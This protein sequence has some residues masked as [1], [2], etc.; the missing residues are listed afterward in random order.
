MKTNNVT[1]TRMFCVTLAFLLF[2]S[3]GVSHAKSGGKLNGQPFQEVQSQID[4]LNNKVDTIE[5]TVEG[6]KQQI[7]ALLAVDATLEERISLNEQFISDLR[8]ENLEIKLEMEEL[9]AEAEVLGEELDTNAINIQELALQHQANYAAI[10]ELQGE[11]ETLQADLDGKQDILD[12]SCPQGWVLYDISPNGAVTCEEMATPQ[13]DDVISQ[14]TQYVVRGEREELSPSEYHCYEWFLGVCISGSWWNSKATSY[15]QCPEGSIL[16]GGGAETNGATSDVQN[17]T[18]AP[19]YIS[20]CVR[21]SE[22]SFI[23][24]DYTD[25]DQVDHINVSVGGWSYLRTHVNGWAGS[26]FRVDGSTGYYSVQS[27]ALCSKYE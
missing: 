14:V 9:A 1:I 20:Y 21:T 18:S 8:A 26:A 25:S 23:C 6:I 10:V 17:Y 24:Y 27:Y 11:V 22:N 16:T 12:T 2:A 13:S 3:I 5:E 19:A 7:S 15:A 4:S